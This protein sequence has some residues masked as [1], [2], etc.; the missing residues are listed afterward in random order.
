MAEAPAAFAPDRHNP[1]KTIMR[2]T[3]GG[4]PSEAVSQ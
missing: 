2:I 3:E 1:G 4:Q